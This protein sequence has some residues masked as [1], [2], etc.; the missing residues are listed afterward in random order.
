M[1]SLLFLFGVQV[2]PDQQFKYV[3]VFNGRLQCERIWDHFEMKDFIWLAVSE[4]GR[5]SPDPS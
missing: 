4:G 2:L 1:F 5:N 3:K